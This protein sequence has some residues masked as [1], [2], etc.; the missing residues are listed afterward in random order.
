MLIDIPEVGHDLMAGE[1]M[2]KLLGRDHFS[3]E[4]EVGDFWKLQLKQRIIVERR[5][6][7][8]WKSP[9]LM[10]LND[11]FKEILNLNLT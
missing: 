10:D 4:D 7:Q 5:N 9:L 6:E 3:F 8:I 2:G 11:D 1:Q